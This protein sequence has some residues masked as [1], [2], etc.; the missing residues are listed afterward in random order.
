MGFIRLKHVGNDRYAY[1]VENTWTSKGPRQTV[2]KYLGKYLELPAT[3]LLPSPSFIT[4]GVLLSAELKARGFTERLRHPEL[5]VTVN[6]K[7]CTVQ[8]ERKNV[9]LG[10]NSGFVCGYTLRR[11][12]HHVPR[13]EV[14]P[15][16]AL[17]RAFSDAGVRV[18]REQFVSI[19]NNA[20]KRAREE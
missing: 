4:P 16:Y 14:T 17:A 20:Y 7:A 6:L 18:S 9:V 10:I 3:P 5:K 11:L 2:T 15:G 8:Q 13:V 1:L 19:Y 12:L